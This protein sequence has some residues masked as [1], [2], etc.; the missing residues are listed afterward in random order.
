MWR[1]GFPYVER[2]RAVLAGA[3]R[4]LCVYSWVHRGT[5]ERPGLVLGL[6][7]GGACHGVAFRIQPEDRAEVVAYLRAREQVTKVYVETERQVLL[8]GAGGQRVRALTYVVDRANPQ[9]AGV[10]PVE[11]QLAVVRGAHGVSGANPDYILSTVAHLREIGIRDLR[12]ERLA[13]ELV[14]GI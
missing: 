11:D 13:S 14:K 7:R 2:Y 4:R 1:P 3:H 5:R 10:L 6:D 12:L 9:Y 8:H